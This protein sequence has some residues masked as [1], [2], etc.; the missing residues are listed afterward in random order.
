MNGVSRSDSAPHI[1]IIWLAILT[2]LGVLAL[3]ALWYPVQRISQSADISYNEG[4]NTYRADM[5]A[6]G[7]PLYGLPPRFTVTN[8]PPLSFHFLGLLGKLMGG[9]TA[10]GRWTALAALA[11]IAIAMAALVRQFAGHWRMGVYAALLFVLGLAVFVPDRIGMNDPQFLGLALSFAGLYLYARNPRSYWLLCA[12]AIAFAISLFTKH[13]L[14]AFPAAVG[15]QLLLQRAWKHFAVWL[16]ALAV[17]SGGL[18]FL[19]FWWDGPYFLA[20]LLAPRS[21]SIMSAWG[22]V[23]PYLLD[24]QILFAAAALWS[25]FYSTISTRNLLAIAFVLANIIGFAFAGGDGVVENV[26]FDALVMV[27]FITAIGMG[28]LESKLISLRFGNLILLLALLI[29][30]LGIFALLPRVLY[31]EHQAKQAQP[32]LDAEFRQAVAFLQGRPGPAFCEDLLLCYDAGKPPL[33]DA[34]YVNSQL[35]IGRLREADLLAYVD[36]GRLP[37]IE[38]EIPAGQLLLPVASFRFSAPVMRAILE[39]YRPAVRNSRFTLLVPNEEL[40]R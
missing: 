27:V 10:A 19:T 4:W 14:L 23:E 36:G 39:R 21:Y 33:F 35:K 18:L 7:E 8:Y 3:A 37:T 40:A 6:R 26:L 15:L 5:A 22:R 32:A 30:Y 9:F 20:H 2:L 11:F 31:N 16:G 29:P 34:F 28:D 1:R 13:N 25:V 12:S 17:M 38:I 24:F